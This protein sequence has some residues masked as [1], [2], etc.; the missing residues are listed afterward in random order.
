MANIQ[1]QHTGSG[2]NDIS[3]HLSKLS[4]LGDILWKPNVKE[5]ENKIATITKSQMVSLLYTVK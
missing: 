5:K 1:A 3:N 2:N 4:Q